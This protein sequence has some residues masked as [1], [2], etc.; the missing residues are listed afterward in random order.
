LERS[1]DDSANRRLVLADSL[2]TADAVLG[3][4]ASIAHGLHVSHEVIAARVSRE[5]PFMATETFLMAGTLRGGDRQ[6]LHEAIRRASLEAHSAVARGEA[7]PLL[8]LLAADGRFGNSRA[9]L[10]AALDA[11]AFTGRSSRQVDEFLAEV[12]DPMLSRLQPAAVED[13]RV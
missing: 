8:D 10:A 12:V 2:L 1:L 11:T 6:A 9:E 13:P 4:G 3:L 5:L 7:N